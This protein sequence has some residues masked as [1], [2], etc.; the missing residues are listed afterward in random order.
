MHRSGLVDAALRQRMHEAAAG[1]QQDGLGHHPL[2]AVHRLGPEVLG[3]QV[4]DVLGEVR[5][6]VTHG[7]E[8]LANSE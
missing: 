6:D 3:Q 5:E 4:A 7:E 8:L 1:G 2:D